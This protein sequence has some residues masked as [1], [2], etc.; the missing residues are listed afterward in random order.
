MNQAANETL[1]RSMIG[2]LMYLTATRPD[3]YFFTCLCVGYQANPK[4]SHLVHVKG[5]FWYVKG[6]PNL[7]LWYP[8]G[9]GFDLKSY[10]DSDYAGCNLDRKSTSGGCQIL[11]EKVVCWSA[12]KKSFVPM[13]STEAE[14]VVVTRCSLTKQPSAFYLKYLKEF[15]LNN[16]KNYD[17]LPSEETMRDAINTLGLADEQHPKLTLVDL[18]NSYPL[19][20]KYFSPTWKILMLYI[21]KCLGGNQ[22]SRDQLNITEAPFKPSLISEVPLTYYMRKVTKLP[23]KPLFLSSVEVNAEDIDDK[24]LFGT[25]VHPF[26]QPKAKTNK[27]LKKKKIPSSS[28]PRASKIVKAD[29]D[30][31]VDSSTQYL[32]DVTLEEL[33]GRANESPF[34]TESEI[35]LV[36][37]F[38]P[39]VDDD[40]PLIT[41]TDIDEDFD[42]ASMPDDEV[43]SLSDVHTSDAKG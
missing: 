16:K 9:S 18:E 14:Y 37:R 5:I 2:T 7:G 23:K 10:S 42:L 21:V 27:S 11:G 3:V 35:K 34:D 15:W 32:G 31:F 25:V 39:L 36:K 30:K 24:S 26:S 19:R 29:V 43:E 8:K 33:N 13:S 38:K 22:G 28:E 41:F 20:L 40:E 12:K 6:T 1:L 4:E 17:P